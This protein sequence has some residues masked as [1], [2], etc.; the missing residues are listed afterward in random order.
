MTIQGLLPIGSVV[1]LK[2]GK[3]RVMITGYAQKLAGRDPIYDYVACLW[4]EG[5]IDAE[6]NI[7]FNGQMIDEVYAVGYQTEAQHV[8]IAK[9][10]AALQKAREQA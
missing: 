7:V 6:Q 2:E 3:H 8:F 1:M 9:V 10:E 4:P 5:F